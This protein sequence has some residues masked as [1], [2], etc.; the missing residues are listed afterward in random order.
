[1]LLSPNKDKFTSD[2][3]EVVSS[4]S[5]ALVSKFLESSSGEKLQGDLGTVALVAGVL[6]GS[7]RVVELLLKKGQIKVES[8][9]KQ[10]NTALLWAALFCKLPVVKTLVENGADTNVTNR[11]GKGA[12]QLAAQRGCSEVLNYLN[13]LAAYSS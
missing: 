8:A 12:A 1:L 10:G 5:I 3:A 7:S 9:G 4:G 13:E 11:D 6:G 2:L